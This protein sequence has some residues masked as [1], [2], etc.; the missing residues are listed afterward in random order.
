MSTT[1][2]LRLGQHCPRPYSAL[3]TVVRDGRHEP[4]LQ[5]S[6]G[7]PVRHGRPGE[8]PYHPPFTNLLLTA[9]DARALGDELLRHAAAL[10]AE[11]DAAIVRIGGAAC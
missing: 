11:E 8:R 1:R 5:L 3:L 10:T 2:N 7:E 4:R 9:D 6:F